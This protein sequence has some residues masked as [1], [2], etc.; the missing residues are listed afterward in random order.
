MKSQ[1]I[2]EL[3]EAI[4]HHFLRP[5]LLDQALTHASHAR[6]A[7]VTTTDV[8]NR[9]ADNEQLEF[10]GDAI[11]GLIASE[12]LFR[13]FPLFREGELSKLKAHLVSER[14]LIQIAQKLELGKY[15]HLGR[16]EENSGGRN[17]PAML[18]NALEA[19]LAAIYLDSGLEPV[20]RIVWQHILGPELQKVEQNGNGL[21]VSDYKSA[22]QEMLQAT[23][24]AQPSYVLVKEYGLAH[25]KTF[26]VEARLFGKD[27]SSK[28][29][30]VGSAEGSTK[31]NAEQSAARQVLE[32]LQSRP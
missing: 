25:S 16:G 15:L 9:G 30:F 29:E 23:G 2:S 31:K 19:V 28:P 27:K 8:P 14:H 7:L 3:Q 10:L 18:A 1:Q 17:K 4:G 6:E 26:V 22:L 5:E 11:L 20:R 32:F 21:P 24:R 13:R 12:E